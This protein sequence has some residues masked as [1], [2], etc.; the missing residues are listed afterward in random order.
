MESVLTLLFMLAILLLS[1]LLACP[2]EI[3]LFK[4]IVRLVETRHATTPNFRKL[5]EILHMPLYFEFESTEHAK[6]FAYEVNELNLPPDGN[7]TFFA[8]QGDDLSLQTRTADPYST[9]VCVRR[10][11]SVEDEDLIRQIAAKHGGCFIGTLC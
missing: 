2:A 8:V 10:R 6:A 9:E 11:A 7:G 5:E 1:F 3:F 4:E